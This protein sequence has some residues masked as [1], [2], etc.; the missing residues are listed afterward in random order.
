MPRILII[1]DDEQIQL[2]LKGTL[3]DEG[4][5]VRIASNGKEGIRCWQQEPFDLVITDLLM[6]EKEGLETIKELRHE[7]PNTKIIAMSGGLRNNEIDV[8]N[9]AKKLGANRTF[10]K[11]VP[12]PEFLKA[13]EE[14]L[15]PEKL[16]A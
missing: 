4:Y 3:E 10:G 8:L 11:P 16:Q 12:L 5:E 6:P 7:S 9:M 1:E 15:E 14:M 2:M 13:V